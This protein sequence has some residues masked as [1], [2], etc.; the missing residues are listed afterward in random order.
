[1]RISNKTFGV[2]K[3]VLKSEEAKKKYFLAFEGVQ[4]EVIY[5]DGVCINKKELNISPT[6][7]LIPLLRHYPHIGWSMYVVRCF[8]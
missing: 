1:M 8:A 2:R 4:T 6:I 5:F 3:T 7:E